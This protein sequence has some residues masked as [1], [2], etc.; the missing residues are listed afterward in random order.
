[1]SYNSF[2]QN[3]SFRI[4]SMDI[5]PFGCTIVARVTPQVKLQKQEDRGFDAMYLYQSTYT[6]RGHVIMPLTLI[7]KDED[8]EEN[9]IYT[10]A[11]IHHE[12]M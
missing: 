5:H 12:D 9:N 1:M 11:H 8:S 4:R 7:N 3:R 2:L 10:Q 6:P